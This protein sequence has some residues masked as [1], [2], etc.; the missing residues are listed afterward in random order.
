MPMYVIFIGKF[1]S[2]EFF[3]SALT[4]SSQFYDGNNRQPYNIFFCCR[5][6]RQVLDET[7]RASLLAPYAARY[8]DYAVSVCG[9]VIPAKVIEVELITE[10]LSLY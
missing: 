3:P 5:Y 9:H 4:S 7:L 1:C 2:V 8:S 10:S 6:T